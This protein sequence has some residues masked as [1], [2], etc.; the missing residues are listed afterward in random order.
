MAGN[1]Q[2]SKQTSISKFFVILQS[3]GIVVIKSKETRVATCTSRYS[4]GHLIP[5]IQ[6]CQ[7]EYL[8]VE[9]ATLA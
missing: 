9:V 8:L 4:S 7:L 5:I 1:L 3:I 2:K 6:S